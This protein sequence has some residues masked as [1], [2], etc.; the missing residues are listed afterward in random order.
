MKGYDDTNDEHELLNKLKAGDQQALTV[1]YYRYINRLMYYVQRTAKS[2]FLAEDVVHDTFI[3]V[4]Q[5]RDQI[6]PSRPFEP[7]LFTIAKRTLLN[8]LRRARHEVDILSE[9]RRHA[10]QE[11]NTTELQLEY[12]ESNLL[13]NEAIASMS[14]QVKQTFILCR[15]EGMSY[16]Q[17]AETLNVTESTINKH[18]SKALSLIR[19]HIRTKNGLSVLL[20]CISLLK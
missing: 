18:M 5:N 13:V 12:N 16:K 8:L 14:G 15:M 1:L 20:A 11:E 2:T 19:E 6:D 7:Y 17:A 10:L 9:I 4:W 3:K